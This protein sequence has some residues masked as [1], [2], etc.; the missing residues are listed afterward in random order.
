[1]RLERMH[2]PREYGDLE[3]RKRKHRPE[4]TQREEGRNRERVRGDDADEDAGGAG[5]Q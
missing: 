5:R 4:A 2:G 1:M 3:S